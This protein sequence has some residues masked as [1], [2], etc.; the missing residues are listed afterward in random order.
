MQ[1]KAGVRNNLW[2]EHLPRCA[3]EYHQ[4]RSAEHASSAGEHRAAAAA[5]GT[6]AENKPVRRRAVGKQPE[7]RAATAP[8]KAKAKPKPITEKDHKKLA[9][10]VKEQGKR[11]AKKKASR[12][13]SSWP[14]S[15]RARY[16]Q[17]WLLAVGARASVFS[18][19]CAGGRRPAWRTAKLSV[20]RLVWARTSS[21]RSGQIARSSRRRRLACSARSLASFSCEVRGV[22]R[23]IGGARGVF[24]I[25]I[26]IFIF[27]FFFFFF[28]FL[29]GSAFFGGSDEQWHRLAARSGVLVS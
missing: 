11:R 25:F 18:A 19:V 29:L 12:N 10:T 14:A 20:R 26:F 23:G 1:T 5:T 2:L 7:A 24:F 6:P 9:K 17:I 15:P 16:G 27:V 8:P 13:A 3:A 4:S 28:F 21:G 22:A